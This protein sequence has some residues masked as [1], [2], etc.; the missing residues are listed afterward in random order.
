MMAEHDREVNIKPLSYILGKES[1]FRERIEK[2]RN[3][4]CSRS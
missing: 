4:E 2:I 3:G 1:H